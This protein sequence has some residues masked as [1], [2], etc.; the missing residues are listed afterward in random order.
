MLAAGNGLTLPGWRDFER[1]VAAAF[2]GL[3]VESKA[4]FDVLLPDPVRPDI[5]YGVSCKMRGT[6]DRLSRDG[7]LTLELSNSAKKFWQQLALQG[8]DQVSYQSNP[9]VLQREVADGCQNW[10]EFSRG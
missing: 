7:R 2:N 8:F 3:A 10:S 5:Y 1:A 4:I 6:L 9:L